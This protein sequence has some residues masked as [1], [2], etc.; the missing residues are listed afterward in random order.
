MKWLSPLECSRNWEPASGFLLWLLLWLW[1]YA[2]FL[3]LSHKL[4]RYA[5]TLKYFSVHFIISI[6][7]CGG[8]GQDPH[9]CKSAKCDM[10]TCT[11]HVHVQRGRDQGSAGAC[12]LKLGGWKD[13]M[14]ASVSSMVSWPV[15]TLRAEPVNELLTFIKHLNPHVKLVSFLTGIKYVM[16]LKLEPCYYC[17]PSSLIYTL[18][19]TQW[20]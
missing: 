1:H 17:S 16:A 5:L 6:L 18:L 15:A 4:S 13:S 10:R 2:A 19:P 14:A 20:Y 3:T 9:G 12:R 11:T 8:P 7:R